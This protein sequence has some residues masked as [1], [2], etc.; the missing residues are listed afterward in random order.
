MQYIL[1]LLFVIQVVTFLKRYWLGIQV[2]KCSSKC[3]NLTTTIVILT[4]KSYT[5]VKNIVKHVACWCVLLL[6]LAYLSPVVLTF[7]IYT[8]LVGRLNLDLRPLRVQ[9]HRLNTLLRCLV[10]TAQI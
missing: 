8:L 3:I 2:Y 4:N 9:T 6:L 1:Q 5:F 10:A 7:I